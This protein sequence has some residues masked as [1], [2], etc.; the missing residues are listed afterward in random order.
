MVVPGVARPRAPSSAAVSGGWPSA[1]AAAAGALVAASQAELPV[2]LLLLGALSAAVV[3]QGG[4]LK[5]IGIVC[6]QGRQGRVLDVP[7]AGWLLLL[8]Q[9]VVVVAV[10]LLDDGRGGLLQR[11]LLLL[12]LA[13]AG[14]GEQPGPADG[15]QR[16]LVDQVD[17]GEDQGEHQGG[18]PGARGDGDADQRHV[19]VDGEEGLHPIQRRRGESR[20]VARQGG[21]GCRE[22]RGRGRGSGPVGRSARC[23]LGSGVGGMTGPC[24]CGLRGAERGSRAIH[25]VFAGVS[26][27]AQALVRGCDCKI[28]VASQGRFSSMC[29]ANEQDTERLEKDVVWIRMLGLAWH[30]ENGLSCRIASH[31]PAHAATAATAAT[32]SPQLEDQGPRKTRGWELPAR[33]PVPCPGRGNGQLSTVEACRGPLTHST[34][35][36]GALFS[37]AQGRSGTCGIAL[38]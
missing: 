25:T 2:G 31:P 26:S 35:T 28:T 21:S 27:T 11:L 1:T 5:G 24:W 23:P 22:A 29:F 32:A 14:E 19:V 8:G 12:R 7:S 34:P 38:V 33:S 13:A 16:G 20:C 10:V 37:F 6:E 17:E 3:E 18:D 4:A 30:S 15:Q 9:A 36:A